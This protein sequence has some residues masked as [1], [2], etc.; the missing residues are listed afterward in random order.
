M[1]EFRALVS[2][3]PMPATEPEPECVPD[4]DP[5]I[6]A[7]YVYAGSTYSNIRSGPGTKYG[8]VGKVITGEIVEVL[9][10]KAD[11]QYMWYLLREVGTVNAI[12]WCTAN[13]LKAVE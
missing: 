3:K 7:L 9:D 4:A 5:D 12:G 11:D 1:D 13:Y 6:P 10:A 2:G 8:V